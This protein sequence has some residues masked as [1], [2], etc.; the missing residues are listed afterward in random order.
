MVFGFICC[1]AI[2][3]SSLFVNWDTYHRHLIQV[4]SLILTLGKNMISHTNIIWANVQK[5]KQ[6]DVKQL[7]RVLK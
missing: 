1:T 6:T 2:F 7:M 3:F 5:Y 4:K